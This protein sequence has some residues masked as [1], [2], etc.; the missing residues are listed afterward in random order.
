MSALLTTLAKEYKKWSAQMLQSVR[1]A[2][3]LDATDDAGVDRASAAVL[4]ARL[5]RDA[6]AERYIA[7]SERLRGKQC[8]HP[9]DALII[10][11]DECCRAHGY[12]PAE[13]KSG[14]DLQKGSA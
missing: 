6:A 9:A 5:R 2:N 10:V 8:G 3:E 13:K 4:E 7:E 12:V 11:C 14:V 1:F